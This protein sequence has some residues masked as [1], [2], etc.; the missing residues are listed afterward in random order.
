MGLN[1]A[2]AEKVMDRVN[3]EI[4]RAVRQTSWDEY[5]VLRVVVRRPMMNMSGPQVP[6]IDVYRYK[7]TAPPISAHS[8][9]RRTMEVFTVTEPL[10]E[11]DEELQEALDVA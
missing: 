6:D 8:D 3:R 1:D 7:D 4:V 5:N 10:I 9:G 2:I 11:R